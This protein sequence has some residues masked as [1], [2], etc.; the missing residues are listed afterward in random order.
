[1]S[2]KFYVHTVGSVPANKISEAISLAYGL[3]QESKSAGAERVGYGTIMTGDHA[4][5]VIF[6][7][8]FNS[9]DDFANVMDSFSTSNTYKNILATGLQVTMR[10]V[11]KFCDIPFAPPATPQ[12]KY[13][14]LTRGKAHSSQAEIIDLIAQSCP[15][16]ADNGAQTVR[17]ARIMTGNNA[18]DFLLGVTYP[19]MAAIETTYDAIATS[20]VAA[21]LYD[22]MDVNLRN[23][24]KIQGGVS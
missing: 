20:P 4:G 11:A 17:L 9:L 22:S 2:E 16:F 3:A 18:G 10:N 14:I 6:Q 19:S 13:L 24:I 8:F 23:I 21:K 12:R 7:Q 1:M 15:L 5:S